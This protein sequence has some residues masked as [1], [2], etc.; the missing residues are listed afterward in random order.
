M[1]VLSITLHFDNTHYRISK[2]GEHHIS[3]FITRNII[4]T[5]FLAGGGG[6]VGIMTFLDAN[7][8]NSKSYTKNGKPVNIVQ[9]LNLI[10]L[11]FIKIT[12]SLYFYHS[13]NCRTIT[14][15]IA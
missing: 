3:I 8:N 5:V 9:V 6:E 14:A 11:V 15:N 13:G 12:L 7:I 4:V 10:Y 2:L 1:N